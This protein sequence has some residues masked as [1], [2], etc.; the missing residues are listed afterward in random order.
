M[1]AAGPITSPHRTQIF[2]SAVKNRL[3]VMYPSRGIVENG[4]L[5]TYSVNLDDLPVAPP[6]TLTKS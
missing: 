4:G 6:R 1:M 2:E 3:P 5:M